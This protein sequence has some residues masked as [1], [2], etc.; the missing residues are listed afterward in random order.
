[1]KKSME[2]TGYFIAKASDVESGMITTNQQKDIPL[3][4]YS[5]IARDGTRLDVISGVSNIIDMGCLPIAL[6]M[7]DS[8]SGKYSL[9]VPRS[10]P[11][12]LRSVL[13]E[14]AP[15]MTHNLLNGEISDYN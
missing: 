9:W 12:W 7:H 3:S 6:L 8:E 5:T 11:E 14:R 10:L 2:R 4:F 1:M 13:S 15:G